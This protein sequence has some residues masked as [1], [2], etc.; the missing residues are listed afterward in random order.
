VGP[1]ARTQAPC[2][3]VYTAYVNNYESTVKF[4]SGLQQHKKLVP[5]FQSRRGPTEDV[6]GD[7]YLSQL[8][9]LP[10][11]RIPRYELL[12]RE[13]IKYTD[14]THLDYTDLTVRTALRCALVRVCVCSH[15]LTTI[16]T[17]ERRKPRR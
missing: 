7:W 15:W 13:M 2:L 9:I 5:F 8:L 3:K 12:L 1:H 11:Q 16:T 10:V 6:R 4:L 17:A 14:D